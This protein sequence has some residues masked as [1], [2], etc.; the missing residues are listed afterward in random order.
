VLR[1]PAVTSALVGANSTSQIED[2][3]GASSQTVFD[4]AELKAIDAILR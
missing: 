2:I 4:A 1:H 3:V